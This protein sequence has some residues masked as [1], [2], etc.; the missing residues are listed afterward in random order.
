MQRSIT[1]Y[2][3]IESSSLGN[4]QEFAVFQ[5]GPSHVRGSERL[6]LEKMLTQAVWKI[7]VEQHLHGVN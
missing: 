6:V 7:F 2:Q 1:G 5:T 3:N 4:V